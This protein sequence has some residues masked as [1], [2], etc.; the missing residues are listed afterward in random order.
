MA[1]TRADIQD[2]TSY[3]GEDV[4]GGG[5]GAIPA[6]LVALAAE[7]S[8]ARHDADRPL[9]EVDASRSSSVLRSGF[10]EQ[11]RERARRLL[12]HHHCRQLSLD[13]PQVA[14]RASTCMNIWRTLPRCCS[15]FILR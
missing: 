11:L 14:G 13:L 9:G 4:G 12:L 2:R 1:G 5:I 15:R 3:R 8:S 10:V 7:P 6:E